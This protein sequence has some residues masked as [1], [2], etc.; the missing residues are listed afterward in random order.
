MTKFDHRTDGSLA[1]QARHVWAARRTRAGVAGAVA[2]AAAVGLAV[3]AVAH[4][5]FFTGSVYQDRWVPAGAQ[6]CITQSDGACRNQSWTFISAKDLVRTNVL[7]AR[8]YNATNH[9]LW[10]GACNRSFVRYC[11]RFQ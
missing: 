7:C 5:A 3:P 9:D 10:S 1:R 2:V 4:Y 11:Q 6:R 8:I